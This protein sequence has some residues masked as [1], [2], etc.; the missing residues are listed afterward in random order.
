MAWLGDIGNATR[1]SMDAARTLAGSETAGLLAA[2][3]GEDGM[4]PRSRAVRCVELE[5]QLVASLRRV[6]DLDVD[7]SVGSTPSGALLTLTALYC[8][9]FP[10]TVQTDNHLP[11]VNRGRWQ[12]EIE[13][14]GYMKVTGTIDLVNDPRSAVKCVLGRGKGEVQG[15][16]ME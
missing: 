10:R 4:I 13:K 8:H 12:Y 1:V 2:I 11:G 3:G 14:P 5:G 6:K 15:C 7:L 9:D 16:Q